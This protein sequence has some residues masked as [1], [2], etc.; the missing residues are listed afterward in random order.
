MGKG[1]WAG[2]PGLEKGG[3]IAVKEMYG[4]KSSGPEP[5]GFLRGPPGAQRPSMFTVSSR[6]GAPLVARASTCSQSFG[7]RPGS[8]PCMIPWAPEG[9]RSGPE[10]D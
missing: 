10:A 2:T 7:A 6:L 8:A 9:V 1:P 3:K 4:T 5:L